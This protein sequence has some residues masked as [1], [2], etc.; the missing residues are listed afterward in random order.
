MCIRDS[1][2]RSLALH[3]DKHGGSD[4]G[5]QRVAEANRVLSDGEARLSFDLGDDFPRVRQN[6]GGEGPYFKETEMRKYFPDKFD[7][8]PFGDEH[9]EHRARVLK[10]EE[11]RRAG[12]RQPEQEEVTE[13]DEEDEDLDEHEEDELLDE[14]EED[15]HEEPEDCLLYT[16]P[17]PRDS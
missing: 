9:L 17:S 11:T 5:F 13:E 6:D 2:T 7:F 16:S 15:E 12:L 1:R 14:H 3:P 8:E 10:Q 4:D